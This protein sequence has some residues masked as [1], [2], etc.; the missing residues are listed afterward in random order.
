M[1]Q[2][3]NFFLPLQAKKKNTESS[4]NK[5]IYAFVGIIIALIII[6]LI[7][8][9]AGIVI[10]NMQIKSYN[11]KIN[12]TTFQAQL[13]ESDDVNNKTTALNQY[14][15]NIS[16]VLAAVSTRDVVTTSLLNKIS[17]T[18]PTQVGFTNITIKNSDITI[19][20][21]ST[22]KVAIAELQH[23][24][25][26]LDKVQDVQVQNISGDEGKLTFTLVCTLKDGE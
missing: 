23:N 19:S 7:W 13:K 2:D 1:R 15:S 22:T 26:K 21:T 5:L 14:D 4:D 10:S 9:T 18:L 24:L 25:A 17:S 16:T 20:G 11:S 3:M 8:N 12:D 6:T